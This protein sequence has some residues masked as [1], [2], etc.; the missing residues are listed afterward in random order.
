M[1]NRDW[2]ST[3][4]GVGGPQSPPAS[5]SRGGFTPTRRK[6][7]VGPF[8]FTPVNSHMPE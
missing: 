2:Q 5:N 1:N 6:T 4:G 3:M 7:G 8:D